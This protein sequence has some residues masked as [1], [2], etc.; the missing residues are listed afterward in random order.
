M[1]DAYDDDERD[2]LIK[3]NRN[4]RFSTIPLPVHFILAQCTQETGTNNYSGLLVPDSWVG[5][6]ILVFT[7]PVSG[8]FALLVNICT[9]QM[10]GL[11]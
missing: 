9:L 8:W 1:L 2:S 4:K 11:V 10:I 6:S 5:I 7:L 3:R